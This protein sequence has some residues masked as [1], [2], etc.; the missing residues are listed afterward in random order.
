[1][2]S[3]LCIYVYAYGEHMVILA[4]VPRPCIPR[5]MHPAESLSCQRD[6]SRGFNARLLAR[7]H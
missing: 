6:I 2:Y 7:D 5:A 3:K 4:R 1:M